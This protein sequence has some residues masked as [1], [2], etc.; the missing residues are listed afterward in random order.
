M[1]AWRTMNPNCKAN[2]SAGSTI[3][4]TLALTGELGSLG[5]ES[6]VFSLQ[7]RD[8]I[9]EFSLERALCL[10]FVS[11][12]CASLLLVQ[13]WEPR[14][15]WELWCRR[16]GIFL[17]QVLASLRGQCL[18]TS[19]YCPPAA[20]ELAILCSS[21]AKNKILFAHRAGAWTILRKSAE[22]TGHWV[23][24]K[25]RNI[26]FSAPRAG[27]MAREVTIPLWFYV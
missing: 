20:S 14:K 22:E 3:L 4:C 27:S 17:P 10:E 26:N 5:A 6:A 24:G 8:F 9:A 2:T 7:Y 25:G 15:T 11:H 13:E 19:C 12:M 18:Q 21:Q 1:I 16:G 23:D